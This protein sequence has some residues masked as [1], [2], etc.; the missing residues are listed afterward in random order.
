MSETAVR[1]LMRSTFSAIAY[2]RIEMVIDDL[3]SWFFTI[4]YYL[5]DCK[6]VYDRF[7]MIYGIAENPRPTGKCVK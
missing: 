4:L 3:L 6:M 2:I 5:H 7:W 1:K